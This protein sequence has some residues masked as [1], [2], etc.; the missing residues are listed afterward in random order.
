[1]AG[2][3]PDD[4]PSSDPEIDY[5]SLVGAYASLDLDGLTY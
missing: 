5:R 2:C 1:M 4:K 3:Q